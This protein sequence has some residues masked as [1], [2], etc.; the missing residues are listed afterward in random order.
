MQ[1]SVSIENPT[2][3]ELVPVSEPLVVGGVA[4]GV[5]GAEPSLID[6]VTVSVAGGAPVAATFKAILPHHGTAP[7]AFSFSATVPFP[8]AT[9]FVEIVVEARDDMGA[10]GTAHVTVIGHEVGGPVFT[11]QQSLQVFATNPGPPSAG[12]WAT[13]I[14]KETRSAA[15]D[16]PTIASLA[17][18]WK[19]GDAFPVCSRE[20]TQV[21]APAEDYDEETVA[22]SGWLLEPELSGND[23]PFAHPFGNDWECMVALDA[24]FTG[25]LAAGNAV[26]DG[27]DGAEAIADAKGLNIPVPAGGLLAIETDSG[28]V[29]TKLYPDENVIRVGDRIVALG[30]WIVDTGHAVE[31]N[32]SSS[33]R[34]EVHPPLLM[35]IGGTRTEPPNE[36]LTRVLL[37]SRPYLVKQVYTTDTGR[38]YDDK[39]S[40]DGTFLWHINNEIEKLGGI[41]PSSTSIEAHPK[42]AS[43]P[44]EGVHLLRVRVRPPAAGGSKLAIGELVEQ[45]QVSFQ[46]TCRSGVGV[47]VVA[48]EDGVD[49]LVTLNSAGYTAPP[50]PPRKTRNVSKGDLG[51]DGQIITLEQITSLFQVWPVDIVNEEQ[52]LAHGIDTDHYDVPDVDL[53]DRSHAVPFVPIGNIPG[54]QGIV[55]D[56]DQP[57]PVFGFLEIRR[58]RPNVVLGH[59]TVQVATGGLAQP[60]AHETPAHGAAP[61]T[62][63]LSP[64]KTVSP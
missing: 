58:Q 60:E 1:P 56:D 28:C 64:K 38:V 36:P 31:L 17:I 30:R 8:D 49:I 59:G 19:Q 27:S 22:L 3:Q 12:D 21:T 6:S 51:E 14:V 45:I 52:A 18:K 50:L 35:A 10:K 5:G 42:I 47:Q 15:A 23:V 32:G 57:Y 43:K 61:A 7:P 26:P 29:P 11:P 37:T 63:K 48:A 9:G 24:E 54:G 34:A 20:W 62:P 44:F 53:L 41:I 4:Y 2:A 39:D 40:G 16:I 13:K 46:F 33:Y 55:V 25:L